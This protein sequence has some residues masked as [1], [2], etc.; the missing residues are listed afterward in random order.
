MS[1]AKVT[2]PEEFS[3]AFEPPP[4]DP[5]AAAAAAGKAPPAPAVPKSAPAPVPTPAV[6]APAVPAAATTPGGA[7][8]VVPLEEATRGQ[9][10]PISSK[11]HKQL[12]E[13]F[14]TT[15][16]RGARRMPGGGSRVAAR[17]RAQQGAAAPAGGGP[18]APAGGEEAGAAAG[19][20]SV[21]QGASTMTAASGEAKPD[22]SWMPIAALLGGGYMA[23][24]YGTEGGTYSMFDPPEVRKAKQDAR[25]KSLGI[26]QPAAPAA[27]AANKFETDPDAR[28]QSEMEAYLKRLRLSGP[29]DPRA[30]AQYSYGGATQ[31]RDLENFMYLSKKR[32]L[33]QRLRD[34]WGPEQSRQILDKLNA[35]TTGQTGGF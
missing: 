26:G 9:G 22:R 12:Q 20:A 19:G 11:T 30:A 6:A 14:E 10:T 5:F 18:G 29:L 25:N 31:A 2:S 8:P 16:G 24:G 33:E 27:G 13:A 17:F 1:G 35:K 21:P 23:H 15:M 4:S 32:G 28:D 7:A 34:Q 3:K